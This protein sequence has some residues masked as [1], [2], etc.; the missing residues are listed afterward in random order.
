MAALSSKSRSE[1]HRLSSMQIT[2]KCT[3]HRSP[4]VLRQINLLRSRRLP[5]PEAFLS[6]RSRTSPCCHRPRCKQPYMSSMKALPLAFFYNDNWVKPPMDLLECH[7]LWE[8]GLLLNYSLN[9]TLAVKARRSG[10]PCLVSVISS[11][12]WKFLAWTWHVSFQIIGDIWTSFIMSDLKGLYPPWCRKWC[13]FD[14]FCAS[15]ACSRHYGIVIP[16]N[17]PQLYHQFLH[18]YR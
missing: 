17:Q 8:W 7:W 3:P 18:V 2:I 6:G 16:E 11:I 4:P 1:G 13:L 10:A 5:A 14:E 15:W 12:K 9:R